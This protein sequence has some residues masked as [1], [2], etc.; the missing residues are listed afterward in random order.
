MSSAESDLRTGAAK[1]GAGARD[2]EDLANQIDAIRAD[3]Q[4]LTSTVGRI[5]S[6]QVNRAQ[7]KAKETAYEAEEAIRRNP[8]S[9]IAIAVGLGFLFGVFTRR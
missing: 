8:L 5:A 6:K 1:R 4:N 2:A 3:L 7:D 9:A